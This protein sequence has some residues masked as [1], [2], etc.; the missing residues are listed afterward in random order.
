LPGEV[1]ESFSKQGFLAPIFMMIA[2]MA[3]MRDLIKRKEATL[4]V[5][6]DHNPLFDV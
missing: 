1:L 4:P 5:N 3:R 6:V 2:S